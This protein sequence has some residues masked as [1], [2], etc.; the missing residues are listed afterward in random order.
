MLRQGSKA[1]FNTSVYCIF[2]G[3]D[4]FGMV[5]AIATMPTLLHISVFLLVDFLIPIKTVVRFSVGVLFTLA[6]AILTIFTKLVNLESRDFYVL[7]AEDLM[8]LGSE[9]WGLLSHQVE[10]VAPQLGQNTSQMVFGG[11]RESVELNAIGA[12]PPTTNCGS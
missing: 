3:I 2:D 6:Y 5:R 9:K 7:S 10:G 8:A 12:P 1:G 4:R 11:P